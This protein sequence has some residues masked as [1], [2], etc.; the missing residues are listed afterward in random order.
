[1]VTV[2]EILKVLIEER[3][4]YNFEQQHDLDDDADW[5]CMTHNI[6]CWRHSRYE[7]TDRTCSAQRYL[8][9]AEREMRREHPE[10]F[11]EDL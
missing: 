1:M 7:A 2:Q 6:G 9:A 4:K 10:W 3:A 5:F 11:M 8:L